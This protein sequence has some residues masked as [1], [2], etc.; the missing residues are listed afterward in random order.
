MVL[1][2]RRTAVQCQ[3]HL[4]HAPQQTNDGIAMPDP[5]SSLRGD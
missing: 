1:Q 3:Q 4:T 2:K 5:I